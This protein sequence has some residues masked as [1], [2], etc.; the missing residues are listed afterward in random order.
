MLPRLF[1]QSTCAPG[2][3]GGDGGGGVDLAAFVAE[4]GVPPA[5]T[6]SVGGAS[7]SSSVIV[8]EDVPQHR[9]KRTRL[10]TPEPL[11]MAVDVRS[12]HKQQQTLT[13][14]MRSTRSTRMAATLEEGSP[15]A[16]RKQRR[17]KGDPG[18]QEWC[19]E[20]FTVEEVA[21]PDKRP[22][23][24]T[25]VCR[26]CLKSNITKR[27]TVLSHNPTK[28]YPTSASWT[29]PS[30]HLKNKHR[31]FSIEALRDELS[32]PSGNQQQMK[33]GTSLETYLDTWHPRTSEWNRAVT[34]TARYVSFANAP[35]HL[36]QT[37]P[38]VRF[39]RA[40]VPRWPS[41][42]KQTIVRSVARQA[43]EIKREIREDVSQL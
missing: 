38:F 22:R 7:P 35:Y 15:R 9:A 5:D 36:A 18:H 37:A 25:A 20:G 1:T 42:S 11:A 27:Y 32:K 29:G 41:I 12:P 39:M 43:N 34:H 14:A 8:V 17:R 3:V 24:I 21:G 13:A 30:N 19:R 26:L 40:F 31:V 28:K 4:R 23:S 6:D 10:T 2:S 33:L 16:P